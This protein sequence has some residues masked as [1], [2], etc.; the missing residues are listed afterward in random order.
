MFPKKGGP[1]LDEF[2][3]RSAPGIQ[4]KGMPS[5]DIVKRQAEVILSGDGRDSA[6]HSMSVQCGRLN[7]IKIPAKNVE[8]EVEPGSRN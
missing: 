8:S 3:S 1:F 6:S 2:A 4:K 7:K 5:V